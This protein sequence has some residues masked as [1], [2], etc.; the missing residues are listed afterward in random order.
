MKKNNDKLVILWTTDNRE[1]IFNM[2]SMYAINSK[3]RGWWNN[4]EVIIWGASVKLAASDTQVQAE[5]LE[6]LHA[7]IEIIA[8]RSCSEN[9]G[10]TSSIEKL[11]VEVKYIGSTITE[12]I[13]NDGNMLAI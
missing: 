11:G 8:C 4:V 7:G 3:N 9:F 1:T 2:L 10:V 12:Y 13:R 5:I 6:M